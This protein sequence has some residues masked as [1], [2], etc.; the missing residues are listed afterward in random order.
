[1]FEDSSYDSVTFQLEVETSWW[2]ARMESSKPKTMTVNRGGNNDSKVYFPRVPG[3]LPMKFLK[4]IIREVSAFVAG[5]A[6]K[7]DTTLVVAKL[8]AL[9]V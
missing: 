1:M 2:P 5:E 8:E 4:R 6:Q 7:D 9:P 3:R